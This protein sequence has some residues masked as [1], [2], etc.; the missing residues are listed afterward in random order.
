[1]TYH[2]EIFRYALAALCILLTFSFFFMIL[3][4]DMERTNENIVIYMLG[5]FSTID[6]QI[7]GF[8]FG[9]SSGS[10]EKSEQLDQ[11]SGE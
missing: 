6:T 2:K 3:F 5:V 1:M 11:P 7:I 8:F 10:K 4:I 9:S